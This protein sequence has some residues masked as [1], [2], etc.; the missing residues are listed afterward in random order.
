MIC[1]QSGQNFFVTQDESS[2]TNYL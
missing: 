1:S 2:Q